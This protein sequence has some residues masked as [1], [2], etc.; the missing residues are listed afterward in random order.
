MCYPAEFGHSTSL[1]VGQ[2]RGETQKHLGAVGPPLGW[3]VA[4]TQEI[5]TYLPICVI[6][7][8]LVILRQM[9]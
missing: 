2:V 6:T 4:D 7:P 3:G 8:N 5:R 1:G 9:M